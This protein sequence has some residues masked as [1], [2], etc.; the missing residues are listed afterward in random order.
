MRILLV[1][2]YFGGGG[3]VQNINITLGGQ[4]TAKGNDL[5]YVLGKENFKI[6]LLGG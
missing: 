4:L 2:N 5:F 3:G 6:D 1:V